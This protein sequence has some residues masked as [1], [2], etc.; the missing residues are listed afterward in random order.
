MDIAV[1]RL[2]VPMQP[3]PRGSTLNA[4][5]TLV[6][7]L[8]GRIERL[9]PRSADEMEKFRA[10]A[11]PSYVEY[12]A[13]TSASTTKVPSFD[14]RWTCASA[15]IDDGDAAQEELASTTRAE[16]WSN[17]T[18]TVTSE[19][20]DSG[21]TTRSLEL[22]AFHDS[23]AVQVPATD[24]KAWEGDTPTTVCSSQ[25]TGFVELHELPTR[26]PD[27]RFGDPADLEGAGSFPP[28]DITQSPSM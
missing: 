19:L 10:T 1:S 28:H 8:L 7:A 18:G 27:P 14:S 9:P 24:A 6:P 16:L 20:P 26:L 23:G 4:S 2:M 3:L 17:V 25:P 22:A 13:G 15:P 12:S 11:P 5:C 21:A